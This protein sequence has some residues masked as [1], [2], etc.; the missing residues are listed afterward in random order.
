MKLYVKSYQKFLVEE[1]KMNRK[2]TSAVTDSE[3]LSL[4]ENRLIARSG[5]FYLNCTK[6]VL[7][8]RKETWDSGNL[9]LEK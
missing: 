5:I 8:V 6:G 7:F 9:Y 3:V 1:V 2:Q 4:S